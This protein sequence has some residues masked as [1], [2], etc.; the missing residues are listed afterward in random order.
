MKKLIVSLSSL[1]FLILFFSS[2]SCNEN[3]G[4][5]ERKEL[6][7]SQSSELSDEFKNYWYAGKAELSSYKLQQARY[8]EIHS[9]TAVLVFVTEDFSK[10]KQV[11]LDH[12]ENAGNDKLP[13][14]KLNFTKKF[15][16]GIYPYSMMMS[17]FSTNSSFVAA[18]LIEYCSTI[19]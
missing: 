10:S 13:V 18:G 7:P 17:A 12:P 16:T 8:G 14:L 6:S 5:K 1:S 9:G 19:R 3:A 15:V 4:A 11:K 2:Q